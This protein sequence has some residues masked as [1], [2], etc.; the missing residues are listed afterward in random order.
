MDEPVGKTSI[1]LTIVGTISSILF[2]FVVGATL[3]YYFGWHK[4]FLKKKSLHKSSS[5]KSLSKKSKRQS[6][7]EPTDQSKL[8]DCLFEQNHLIICDHNKSKS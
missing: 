4:K 5:K 6:E 7:R 1:A 8:F 3:S 2:A